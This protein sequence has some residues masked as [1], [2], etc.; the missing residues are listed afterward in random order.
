[1][2]HILLSLVIIGVCLYIIGM[3]P[4]PIWMRNIIMALAILFVVLWIVHNVFGY[5]VP[6][7]PHL[8]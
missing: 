8:K 4:M 3:V 1:M 5:P 2:I 7:L 6:F